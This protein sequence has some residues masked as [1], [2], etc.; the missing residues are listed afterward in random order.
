MVAPLAAPVVQGFG[1]AG[2]GGPATGIT[3]APAPDASVSSPCDGRVAF[4]QPFRSYGK[5]VIVECRDGIDWVLAGFGRIDT[6]AGRAVKA[7]ETLGR[8][9]GDT[10]ASLY[11][12][13]RKNGA[14]VDPA[15]FLKAHG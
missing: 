7:G 6:A 13:V 15:P 1:A 5:L 4:A 2:L 10:K 9:P 14:A 12:E 8:L 11:V 3:Y